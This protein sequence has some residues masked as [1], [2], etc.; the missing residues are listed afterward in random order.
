MSTLPLA[1]T[2]PDLAS[3]AYDW[4]PVAVTA[5]SKKKVK[6]K[7]SRGH[8]YEAVVNKRTSRGDGCSIC[9]GQQI[10]IGYNDLASKFPEIAMEAYGWDPSS[11]TAGTMKKLNWLCPEGHVYEAPV[12]KRT[13][14]GDN[15]SICGGKTVLAGF[16]DLASKLP[17]VAK[18]AD[19]WD[20]AEFAS[21]SHVIKNWICA[22]GHSY[23]AR[24]STRT[25]DIASGCP[26]CAN[27]RLLTGFNDLATAFPD[28]A[29]EADG[30]D[31]SL[32]LPGIAK[33][34][35]WKCKEGHRWTT[36]PNIR[37]GN[38]KS[39]CPTC[40]TTGFNPNADGYLYFLIHNEWEMYQIGITNVPDD[41]LARH[42][43]LGW[44]VL[45]VRGPMDGHLTQQWE[46][47]ILRMLK[48]KDAD[49]SNSKVSGKFD[50][51]SEAWSKS[52][53][54]AKSIKEL[55]RLTDAFEEGQK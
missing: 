30:W 31:A 22:R 29:K 49:L 45:E 1:S 35:D 11:V 19:G 53:F 52:T 39:G 26:Y 7:C 13:S 6:W 9:S 16:N 5:G 3:E 4:D 46:T 17:E 10:L 23:E 33:Q 50:G 15:C 28:I 2:H 20:P 40:S 44:E 27:K 18:Q 55:M 38:N 34:L 54:E 51:Y 24:I 12:H 8:V 36:S 48:A 32:I 37:T 43:R 14:R 41:R 25:R 21:A 47:A 42:K